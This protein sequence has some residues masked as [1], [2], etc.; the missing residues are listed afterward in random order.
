M[1]LEKR[2]SKRGVTPGTPFSSGYTARRRLF[3]EVPSEAAH[4][5]V[6]IVTIPV[7]RATTGVA[8]TAQDPV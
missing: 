8:T 7:L 6:K 3:N 2:A 4:D 1:A 5:R